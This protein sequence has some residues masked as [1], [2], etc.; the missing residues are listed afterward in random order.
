MQT[1]Q[2][3]K[4]IATG[5]LG[6]VF[7]S[8]TYI[9]NSFLAKTGGHWAWTTGLRTTLLVLFLGLMLQWQ[10]QLWPLLQTMRRHV[11][12]WVGWGSI[13][14]GF[15]Y[16]LLTFGAFFGP[17]WLVAGVFQF[18]IVAGILI[19]PFIYKDDRARIPMRALLLSVLILAGIALM[20]WSQ[21]EGSYTTEQLLCCIG[22]VLTAAFLWPLANRKL[23]LH[24]EVKQLKLNAMQRVAGTAI[25][26][27]PFNL[28]LMTFGYSQAGWPSEQQLLAVSVIA[29]SSGVLGCIFFFKAMH[30]ARTN[31][32]AMAA[33]EATQS[34]EILVTV[35]GE[36]LLL[37]IAWPNWS[38]NVGMML[39]MGGLLLY[40]IPVRRKALALK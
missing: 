11:W 23:M 33:V 14:F 8:S 10:G 25:G 38:G 24:L 13:A 37:G 36:V 39:I 6:G 12:V 30:M 40:S 26:S 27:L 9:L 22:L 17:G 19:A 3:S 7:F 4:A 1:S 2:H 29:V 15:N 18:T 20:Q 35:I 16:F 31:G 5:A 21:K 28:L 34:L 32:A